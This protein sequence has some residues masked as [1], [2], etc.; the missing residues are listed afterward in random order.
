MYPEL[1]KLKRTFSPEL[2]FLLA[3]VQS[4]FVD[5]SRCPPCKPPVGPFDWATFIAL[6]E[7]H[8]LIPVIYPRLCLDPGEGM[9]EPVRSQLK[10]LFK[11]NQ[12]HM[13]NL[14]GQ[15]ARI[16]HIFAAQKI[17]LLPLKGPALSQLL[18]G[19]PTRRQSRD[20]DLL[21]V[22]D[23][24]VAANRLLI[25]D[26]FRRVEPEV[27]LGAAQM[28]F[29]L[30]VANHFIYYHPERGLKLELHWRSLAHN[31][32]FPV[33]TSILF[34]RS[35]PGEVAGVALLGLGHD[36]LLYFLA[37]H[38]SKH[39]W[40]RMFWLFDVA[41]LIKTTDSG[42]L[43]ALLLSLR[44]QNLHRTLSEGALLAH[45]LWELP[46]PASVAL[47][48]REERVIR[49]LVQS[50][51]SSLSRIRG[52][53]FVQDDIPITVR[54]RHSL[55]LCPTPVAIGQNLFNKLTRT[56][57]DLAMCKL[58]DSLF[59]LYYFL[60]WPFFWG[61]RVLIRRVTVWMGECK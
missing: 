12:L 42:V 26:G 4:S 17:A 3:L 43:E 5:E 23:D 37:A 55:W 58:P 33:D 60:L 41:Q 44:R 2:C 48:V 24:L 19:D 18:Y 29:Y 45:L 56:S 13:F 16:A 52:D 10:S 32:L 22:E 7:H 49:F 15:L 36:D 50:V 61:W 53:S 21:I 34:S 9:P 39:L 31:Y 35:Q 14:T 59:L 8:R 25:E 57:L 47:I 6:V 46:L 11:Q 54:I 28:R 40:F 1:E 30:R 20:L 38:G 27:E 51:L